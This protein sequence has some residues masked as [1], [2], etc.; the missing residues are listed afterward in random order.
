MLCEPV[1]PG[2]TTPEY[3]DEKRVFA[4]IKMIIENHKSFTPV[5]KTHQRFIH[6]IR[7]GMAFLTYYY[8]AA[9]N[10]NFR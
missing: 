1:F 5:S 4:F 10:R 2:N 9:V 3:I 6:Q 8:K 7:R